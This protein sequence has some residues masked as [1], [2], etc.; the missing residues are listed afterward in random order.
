M[1]ILSTGEKIKRA[2]IF[3]GITL[4]QLCENKIS[5][6]KMSCIENGKIKADNELLKY[7]SKK[8]EID[9]N[10]LIEDVYEQI[11][12]NLKMIKKNISCDNDSENKLKD[13]LSYALK[14][15]YYDLAFKLIHILFSYYVEQNKA[16]NIQ[17]IVSQYYDL[18]QRNNTEENTVIYF[19][20]MARYLSQNG[21]Y[22][23]AISYYSKLREMLQQK[24]DG[25]DNA[26]YCLI[27]YNEALCYQNIRK[28][29]EA[30]SILA[31]IIGYVDKLKT[32][33]SKGK[34]YH[35]YTTV[36]IKLKK[37]CADEYK[38]KAFE[39]Q[40]YNPISLAL[41]HGN[42]GKYYFEVGEQ[43]KA[44]AEIEKGIKIFP[45]DNVEKNVEFLNYCTKILIENIE[46]EIAYKITEEAL[47]MAIITDN[48]K[49]IEKSYYLKGIILQKMD[50]YIEAEKYMNLSLDSLFKFG[51]RDERKNRYI[52]MGK[53]YYALEDTTE[54]LKYFNLALAVDKKI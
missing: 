46:Y 22:I 19:K 48:I 8:I 52:D 31:D 39:Y 4:K 10:Y 16:E 49:L 35:I 15:K 7:I 33:E 51:T 14:Y 41:S 36:C 32:D 17:L 12:N 2:R 47:N 54:S 30:Y 40:K 28:T 13:N 26:E 50:K 37:D 24:K 5:I 29:E 20:D 53:L 18:F 9:L 38:K 6:A 21:E 43:E 11:L 42:Y 23:E 34:I 45:R 3:K 25:F 27:G 1:E 44:I